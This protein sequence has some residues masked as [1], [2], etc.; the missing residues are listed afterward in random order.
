MTDE[1]H[2]LMVKHLI[3]TKGKHLHEFHDRLGQYP[4]LG[5]LYKVRK[6]IDR[7]LKQ[8]DKIQNLI[9]NYN[10]LRDLMIDLMNI[11]EVLEDD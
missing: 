6:E 2:E 11:Y 7:R 9:R 4:K 10:A 1:L 3:L 5:E 8:H